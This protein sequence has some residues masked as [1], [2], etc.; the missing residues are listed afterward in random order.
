MGC[1][2]IGANE[3][4]RGWLLDY[5]AAAGNLY[6]YTLL[7]L[8]VLGITFKIYNTQVILLIVKHKNKGADI[9]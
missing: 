8:K 7:S 9:P 2:L 6:A 4:E 1:S 3:E 5:M